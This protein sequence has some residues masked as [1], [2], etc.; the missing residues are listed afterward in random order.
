M[1]ALVVDA[2]DSFV[3]IICQYLMKAG[4]E[5][6]VVRNDQLSS[7]LVEQLAPDFVVLG[8]GPGHPADARYIELIRQ[9]G[10]CLPILGVCLGHQAIGL[11]F[12][13]KVI[14][15]KH[16]M[17]GKTSE[18]IHDGKGCFAELHN[19]FRATRYHSLIVSREELPDCLEV[20][21]E[22]A[23]DGYIMGVRHR[24]LPIE[25]IQ[26]HPESVCTESG[27]QIFHNFISTYVSFLYE[28]QII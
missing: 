9:Y 2:Y 22:S 25:S 27:F 23:D 18:I 8:P 28:T 3:F 13:G 6:E 10:A 15:A 12:G 21:A 16:L 11:A 7:G 19:P 20:T 26:F 14:G 5:L 24:E 1:R 4:V 17:H